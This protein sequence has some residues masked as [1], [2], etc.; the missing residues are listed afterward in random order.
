MKWWGLL[1]GKYKALGECQNGIKCKPNQG[2]FGDLS[3]KE[4]KLLMKGQVYIRQRLWIY[5]VKG[6]YSESREEYLQRFIC[7]SDHSIFEGH[8]I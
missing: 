7:E 1:Q 4:H 5:G 3:V 8:G 2:I 6:K